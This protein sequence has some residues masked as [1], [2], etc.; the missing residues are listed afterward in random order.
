MT[1]N[2]A[3]RRDWDTGDSATSAYDPVVP[4][5]E[6]RNLTQVVTSSKRLPEVVES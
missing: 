4:T 2:P 6:C 5:Q 3:P 1:L